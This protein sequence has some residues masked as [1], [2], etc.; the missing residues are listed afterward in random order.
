M[1]MGEVGAGVYQESAQRLYHLFIDARSTAS[2][3]SWYRL[4]DLEVGVQVA[5]CDCQPQGVSGKDSSG[6]F[7][8]S[9]ISCEFFTPGPAAVENSGNGGVD[10]DKQRV[11]DR[12]QQD[13][14]LSFIGKGH[15]DN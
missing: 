9:L 10:H 6:R 11:H 5:P 1:G 15:N 2:M 7:D 14:L 8:F 13:K 12:Y 3:S 4:I